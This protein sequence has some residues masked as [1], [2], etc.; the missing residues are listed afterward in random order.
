MVSLYQAGSGNMQGIY[1]CSCTYM[2]AAA[3]TTRNSHQHTHQRALGIFIALDTLEYSML[4]GA[5]VVLAVHVSG[6][7]SP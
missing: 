5:R 1:I 3:D 4:I 7:A 2:A 6:A